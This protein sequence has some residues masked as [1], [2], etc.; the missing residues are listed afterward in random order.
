MASKSLHGL[1]RKP[2]TWKGKL[3]SMA[4]A[5]REDDREAALKSGS[6]VEVSLEHAIK[7]R[8][9]RLRKPELKSLFEG[10]QSP[11]GTFSAKIWIG[12]ALGLYGAKAKHDLDAIKDIRN[13]FAHSP[14]HLDFRSRRIA[15]RCYSMHFV[16]RRKINGKRPK[17]SARTLFLQATRVFALLLSLHTSNTPHLPKSKANGDLE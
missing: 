3:D 11:L 14:H 16:E 7:A 6:L 12:Y 10:P 1:S 9:I 15:S 4:R 5:L 2:L 13:A 8:I 17:E